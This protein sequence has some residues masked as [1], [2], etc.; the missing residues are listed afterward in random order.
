MRKK[1]I[2]M[3]IIIICLIL[4]GTYFVIGNYFYN[5]SLNPKKDKSFILGGYEETEEQL[6][7]LEEQKIWL[8][9]NS[10]DIYINATNNGNLKLHAYE[11][12]NEDSDVW[13]IAVHGYMSKASA[14]TRFAQKFEERGYNVLMPDLRGHG[15][16]EGK[17]VG[18]GWHDRLDLIDWINYLLEKNP[19]NNIILYGISMGA[20]TVMM[21][22]GEELPSNVKLAIADCGYT[23]V[24]DEFCHQMNKLF[25][26]CEFP[27][28]Y[29]ANTVCK[30]RAGYSF[31]EAS[32]IEQLKKSKTPTLFIHGSADDFVPFEML[33]KV[34]ETAICEKEKLVIEGATHG[35]A[36]AV[37]PELYWSKVDEF[38]EKHLKE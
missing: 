3:A 7:K 38:L 32:C 6:Q 36:S 13:V 1:I 10:K 20:S 21:A 4:V 37:N 12:D 28:L 2:L 34:Y 33:D 26:L 15:F 18:M 31:R 27:V 17:Y 5:F 11:I 16:S 29:A 35:Q 19:D 8:E 22:T 9:E 24:W 25:D 30:I 23:C 14:L